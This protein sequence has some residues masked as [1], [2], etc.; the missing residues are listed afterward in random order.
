MGLTGGRLQADILGGSVKL[1]SSET[2]WFLVHGVL[3]ARYISVFYNY[4]L[5]SRYNLGST[6]YKTGYFLHENFIKIGQ[7]QA[8]SATTNTIGQN[9]TKS[10]NPQQIIQSDPSFHFSF[11][12]PFP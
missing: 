9:Y 10:P 3:K 5:F 2:N 4:T 1:G 6:G 8:K 12:L 11:S 7:N